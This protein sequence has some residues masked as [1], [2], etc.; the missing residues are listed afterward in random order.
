MPTEM[1]LTLEQ[2][3]LKVVVMKS[4]IPECPVQYLITSDTQGFATCLTLKTVMDPLESIL[5]FR[6]EILSRDF[7]KLNLPV[8]TGRFTDLKMVVNRYV[9][10][11][12]KDNFIVSAGG[13]NTVPAGRTKHHRR[14]TTTIDHNPLLPDHHP[15]PPTSRHH[16]ISLFHEYLASTTVI[17]TSRCH[18]LSSYL[19]LFLSLL[20]VNDPR[21]KGLKALSM[22]CP[23]LRKLEL[24]RCDFCDQ[25]IASFWFNVPSLRYIWV[26]D[27][28]HE[29][30]LALTRQDFGSSTMEAQVLE[31]KP[32]VTLAKKL[33]R[34]AGK[35]VAEGFGLK[36][37][38]VTY[39]SVRAP[40]YLATRLLHDMVARGIHI[41]KE[42]VILDE[43]LS[44]SHEIVQVKIDDVES[45]FVGAISESKDLTVEGTQKYGVPYL[46]K[47]GAFEV[48][49]NLEGNII[50]CRH[51]DQPGIIGSV[52]TILGEEKVN[53]SF[54]SVG[55]TIRKEAVM[56][57]V[58][59]KKPRLKT[60]K[61]IGESRGVKE[62]VFLDL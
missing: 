15:Q 19:I 11:T 41:S 32:Y 44:T 22:R 51:V 49:V 59:D 48:D 7:L 28:D 4:R 2:T 38:N 8:H 58:V 26:L 42:Q 10:L 18:L 21:P 23:R 27:K 39:A 43:P 56:A 13:P 1:E 61:K 16:H 25:D 40:D 57:I 52:G 34:L 53:V 14:W 50:L 30:V 12:G 17:G 36:F 46:T 3:R 9:V 6:W 35:L 54:M 45:R 31:L 24:E 37:V 29:T 60:L 47:V 5:Y 20:V 33:N 62:V 55:K